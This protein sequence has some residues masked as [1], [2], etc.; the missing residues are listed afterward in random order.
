MNKIVD[1]RETSDGQVAVGAVADSGVS[2]CD[3]CRSIVG[4]KLAAIEDADQVVDRYHSSIGTVF[5]AISNSEV[6]KS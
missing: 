2:A 6:A 1:V 4:I 5:G 3:V